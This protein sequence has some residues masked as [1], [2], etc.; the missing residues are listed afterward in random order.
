MSDTG[1]FAIRAFEAVFNM[2]GGV[3]RIT[4]LT[5]TCKHCDATTSSTEGNLLH[6]PGGTLFRCDDCGCHQA[7]S[8]ARVADWQLPRVLGV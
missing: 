2:A 6:L 4:A 8:N 3:E 1:H 5:V 7:V